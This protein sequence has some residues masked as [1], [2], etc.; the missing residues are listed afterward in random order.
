M[1]DK[2]NLI[3]GSCFNYINNDDI[4]NVLNILC[5]LEYVRI[6]INNNEECIGLSVKGKKYLDFLNGM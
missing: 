4:N 1:L 3:C 5:N 6:I 2:I